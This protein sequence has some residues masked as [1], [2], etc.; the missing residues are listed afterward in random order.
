MG[1]QENISI[2]LVRGLVQGVGFRPFIYRIAKE[3]GICGEV[4]NRNEGV[5]IKA[6]LTAGQKQRFLERIRQ[7]HPAAASIHA[8]I[9]LEV[10]GFKGEEDRTETEEPNLGLST[11][12]PGITYTGFRIAPSRSGS[13][14][15]TQVSPDIAVCPECLADRQQQPLRL[16]YPFINCTHCGP[17]FSIIRDLPYDRGRTTMSRFPMCPDC[18]IEYLTVTDRRFH[19]QPIACN[20]CGPSYYTCYKGKKYTEYGAIL[21]LTTRLL[22]QGKIIAAKGIG[23]YHLVCDAT[24]ETAINRLR[25]IKMRDT[26]PFAV[27]CR[28]KETLRKYVFI[29]QVEE[30]ALDSWRRP[31]VL[32]RQKESALPH[33][34]NPGMYTLGCM[35]PY[36][37]IHYDWFSQ[38]ETPLLVMTSGNLSDTPIAITAEEAENRLQGKAALLLHHNREIYNRV[39]DSVLQ[40][41][42]SLPCLIRRS[43][44]YVPEPIFADSNLEGILAFGA[45][46]VNTFALGKGQTVL[47]SQYI[48]DLKN[49]ET[50]SFYKQSLG[51][52]MR[53]VRF[54]PEQ[55]VCDLHPDYFSSREAEQMAGQLHLPLIKVQHHHAH[56]VACMLEY[57]LREPVLAVVMDGTGLGEDGKIWGGEFLLCDRHHYT[58][59]AHL[60]YVPL[61]GGDKA[62]MEPWRM[63][64]ALG[65]HYGLTLPTGF[66]KRIGTTRIEMLQRMIEKGVNTPYTSSAGRIFDAVA[67]LLG[68][69]DVCGRQ[70]EAPVLLEQTAWKELEKRKGDKSV[71]SF[72][73]NSFLS[74]SPALP[75]TESLELSFLFKAIVEEIE[76]SVTPGIIA[77]RFHYTLAALIY[78]KTMQEIRQTGVTKVVL[79]GGCFQNKLLTEVLQH[80]FKLAGIPLYIPSRIPCNDSGIAVGQL[81]IAGSICSIKYTDPYA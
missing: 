44:G 49:W 9:E 76:N 40:V 58:R 29:N 78:K 24:N 53:L 54:T 14:E 22:R 6:A 51:H 2:F 56:A 52:F 30:D 11:N 50:Y 61:P 17:R 60:E 65:W 10:N 48:G 73:D 20:H 68:I 71:Q 26:K 21:E 43:R 35:L 41:C 72:V 28:D 36:M 1:T 4:D 77:L 5:Y 62:S 8:I 47:Q 19:A 75:P 42:G 13:D 67:S 25:E 3:M 59:R 66:V 57:G 15:V 63:A 34:L 70:A 23:G 81:A 33:A 27:M 18:R 16:R 80:L 46:Q 69:C 12:N 74:V 55:L 32:L 31:I 39:D 64:V 7:E 38:L 37:P 45:E 79:S